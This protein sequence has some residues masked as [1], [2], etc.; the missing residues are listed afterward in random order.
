[1][2]LRAP[3]EGGTI[4]HRHHDD[5]QRIRGRERFEA[6][7]PTP[8]TFFSRVCLHYTCNFGAFFEPARSVFTLPCDVVR[9]SNEVQFRVI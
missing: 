8:A 7:L 4:Y 2:R 5:L 9:W 3:R 6:C 1:M